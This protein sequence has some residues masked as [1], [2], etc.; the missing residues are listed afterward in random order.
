MKVLRREDELRFSE[1]TQERYSNRAKVS[2]NEFMEQIKRVT[3]ELQLQALRDCGVRSEDLEEALK[4]VRNF[5]HDYRDDEE[6]L[7]LSVYGRHDICKRG[8]L[9][10]GQQ[11]PDVPVYSLEGREMRLVDN[12]QCMA[13][14]KV[15]RELNEEMRAQW[16]SKREDLRA[17]KEMEFEEEEAA[18]AAFEQEWREDHPD[19]NPHRHRPTLLIASS[20]S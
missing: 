9:R 13:A 3:E 20:V 16:C 6:V 11:V 7:Q 4:A 1:E 8:S 15:V 17:Q 12:I 18:R 14:L 10:P 2:G 5:R 19:E